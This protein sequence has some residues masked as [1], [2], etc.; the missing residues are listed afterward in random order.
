VRIWFTLAVLFALPRAAWA[1]DRPPN[2]LLVVADDLRADVTSV[3]GGP[4]KTP[5]LEALAARGSVFS[6]A[7]CGYPV[8]HVSRTELITGRCLVAEAS[9]GRLVPLRTEWSLWPEVMRR[10]GWQT[11]YSGK[12]HVDGTPWARGYET[13]SRL[14]SGGGARGVPLTL[15]TSATGRPVTG[16]GGWT[17]RTND[18]A[19]MPELGV[20]L[21]P[22]TD[23]RIADGAIDAIR[24]MTPDRPLFL[25][26]NFTAPHDP[27]HWPKAM[28]GRYRAVDIKLPANF[29]PAHPF[30]HGNA[31]GRDEVIVPAPRSKA[32]VRAERAVYYAQ[33]ECVDAQLGRIVRAL[34]DRG[35]LERTIVVFT[36][37]QG[38]AIGSHGLMGK[39][40][41]YEH[42][43]QVPLI[44]A[45]PGIPVGQRLG[46][47][48]AIRDLYPTVCELTGRPVPE[49]VE[50]KSLVPVLRGGRAEVHDAVFGY[51]TD[52]Q[53]MIR[54]PDGW[55]LIWYPKAGRT[56]LFDVARDP[57]ELKDLS[58]GPAHA[59]RLRDL[60]RSLRA[61]LRAH[62]D[63]LGK[64]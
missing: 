59:G 21:T 43:A 56:Q 53:R 58:A 49:S 19:P 33:V 45:G 52:T 9:A 11:V 48:C 15:G 5:N 13:T 16:Y 17:F 27:L 29:L 44:L 55:K 8:C 24:A 35:E 42:T 34:S 51:F 46:A 41:N 64:E 38:L 6:R 63:P 20:G 10:A 39:Q 23:A 26:V 2:V 4:V 7:T 30:D 57:D 18:N 25:H 37:D 40:N 62:G 14:Y 12:W 61:W 31:N 50:G 47:Q 36:S 1:A 3:Y 28:E 22:E 32:D 60:T 54:T